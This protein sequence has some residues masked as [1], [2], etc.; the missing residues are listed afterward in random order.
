MTGARQ[1][2][3]PL[4]LSL[5]SNR[6]DLLED[7]SNAEAL[8]LAD[9][10]DSWPLGRLAIFGP[11]SVGKSHLGRAVVAARGWRLLIG[12]ALRGLPDPA[13][14]G[15][16]LD[17][18]DA[19]PEETALLHLVNLCAERG[20]R[21]L[22]LARE[23]P[24][25]WP[26]ALPDLASRLRATLAVGIGTPGEDLLAALL[27][28]HFADRQLRVAAEVQAWLLARL[29]RDAASIAEAA[30]RLDRAA[31]VARGPVTRA[32]ARAALAGWEGFG[33]A[34]DGDASETNGPAPSPAAPP[35]L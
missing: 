28:K 8:A 17:D 19:V 10:P 25:R 35:L 11:A 2:P 1:F 20:E 22:L 31:L 26:V 21:L 4:P 29:A 23:A 24:A 15:T 13:P 7:A 18:A 34:P 16:V 32:L 30:A 6:A 3:L 33:E 5:S 12:P 9:R 14:G 27:A